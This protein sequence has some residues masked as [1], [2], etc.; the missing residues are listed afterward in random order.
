M[1]FLREHWLWM[2]HWLT[3][4]N[5]TRATVLLVFITA[6]YAWLTYRMAKAMNRQTRAQ[7]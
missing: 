2:W 5:G 7:V 4:E 3:G 1:H 6:W